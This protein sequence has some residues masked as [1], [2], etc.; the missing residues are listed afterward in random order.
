MRSGLRRPRSAL[1]VLIALIGF[2]LCAVATWVQP[3]P[4]STDVAGPAWLLVLYPVLLAAPLAWRRAMPLAAFAVIIGTVV[5]QALVTGDSPEGIHLMYTVGFGGFA[6]AA[7]T[8]RRH[9]VLGL[10][11]G[12]VGFAIY[13]AENHDVRSGQAGEL[14]AAAFFGIA[15]IAVWLAGLFVRNRGEEHRIRTRNAELERETRVA[16]AEERVRLA[17]ELHD[18]VAHNLSVVVLQA[19]GARASGEMDPSTL[20]KIERS[21]RESLVEMR[22]LLGVLR[23]DGAGTG[24]E[25]QPGVA[26]IDQ[27]A[28]RVRA[29]GV[30][31]TVTIDGD[32]GSLPPA[33]D[34]SVYRIV[35]ESLTNVLKHAGPAQAG[36]TVRADATSVTVDVVDDGAVAPSGP[37]GGHGLIGM[38]ERVALF[39]GE[40][41]AGPQPGGGF[42]VR[43]VLRREGDG[44]R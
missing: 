14:W 44:S 17:R 38:R 7:Y 32:C 18:V 16:V 36:V 28:E 23:R 29:A 19:A 25:P 27:L 35:Q 43:A 4:I 15:L 20:E 30:P 26:K 8:D 12:M 5:L 3:N 6:V 10:I 21:G 13:S 22:R 37:G 41:S 34:A 11:I 1:D 24:T 2:G 31:V 39:G 40:L 9:A 33:L 42:A